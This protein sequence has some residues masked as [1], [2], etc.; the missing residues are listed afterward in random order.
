MTYDFPSQGGEGDRCQQLESVKATIE[1]HFEAAHPGIT[2][3]SVLLAAVRATLPRPLLFLGLLLGGG[4]AWG[5]SGEAPD[6]PDSR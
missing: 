5:Q 4:L 1:N 6:G 3:T 2:V